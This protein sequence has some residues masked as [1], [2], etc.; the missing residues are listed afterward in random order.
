[1]FY[2]LFICVV[3]CVRVLMCDIAMKYV[4]WNVVYVY[5]WSC[6]EIDVLVCVCEC[7]CYTLMEF[8]CGCVCDSMN[9]G[10]FPSS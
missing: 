3:F 2:S 10:V 4:L 7:M 8:L 9:W 6:Y 1:M 5:V